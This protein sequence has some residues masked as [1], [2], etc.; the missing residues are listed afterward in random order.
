MVISLFRAGVI[1]H[2]VRKTCWLPRRATVR[3]VA[4]RT[5][6]GRLSA[7]LNRPPKTH[8]LFCY[9]SAKGKNR[10]AVVSAK[11]APWSRA[12]VSF[13]LAG[14]FERGA[15]IALMVYAVLKRE[16]LEGL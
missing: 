7:I 16:R 9:R 8:L 11:I 2:T 6:S 10:G 15:R 1:S 4:Q 13:P 12:I 5:A 3:H 14:S